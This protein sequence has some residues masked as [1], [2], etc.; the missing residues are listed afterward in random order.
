MTREGMK[1][2]YAIYHF[3]G[4]NLMKSYSAREIWIT[5]IITL[6]G[7]IVG[8][9]LG[10]ITAKHFQG[11]EIIERKRQ[12]INSALYEIKYNI[13][14]KAHPMYFDSVKYAE[15]LHPWP[16]LASTQ[17]EFLTFNNRLFSD[18]P[19]SNELYYHCGIALQNIQGFNDRIE[20]RNTHGL[21]DANATKSHNPYAYSYY[22]SHVLAKL[23]ELLVF[24]LDNYEELVGEK[25]RLEDFP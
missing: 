16:K 13:D 14:R 15:S 5:A 10:I 3:V 17:I 12:I 1:L 2:N 18:N 19:K 24:L 7:A 21:V 20:S 8:F 25:I 4:K 23:K 9:F 6:I 11:Q 22:Q